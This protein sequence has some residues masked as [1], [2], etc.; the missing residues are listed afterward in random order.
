[1]KVTS[2]NLSSQ[3]NVS[4]KRPSLDNHE[5]ELRK[6]ITDLQGKK[7]SISNAKDKTNEEKREERQAV[8]E[9]IQTLNNE[10][11]QYQ[12]KKRQEEAAKKAEDLKEA[13]KEAEKESNTKESEN[14]ES[15]I[16]QP[17]K[18]I[19]FGNK[20]AGVL[21]SL[22]AT[23]E[24]IAHMKR[25]RS[26]LQRKQRTAATDEEKRNLQDKV[27]NVSKNLGKK[28]TITEDAVSKYHESKR[29]GT[30]KKQVPNQT[31]DWKEQT[32][33]VNA[34]EEPEQPYGGSLFA[35]RKKFFSTVSVF[36]S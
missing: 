19:V 28:V 6:Q 31:F 11:R 33:I 1:M 8:Q 5:S 36:V 34:A 26:G 4:S 24:Q 20:D 3:S 22:S 35:N 23:K 15:G 12:I 27:N 25:I 9:E 17:A 30:D 29:K 21:I 32:A 18:P 16:G 14:E 2:A 13:N 7:K 10:L